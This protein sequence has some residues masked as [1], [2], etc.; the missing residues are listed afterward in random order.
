VSIAH[1]MKITGIPDGIHV[2]DSIYRQLKEFYSFREHRYR[3][4]HEKEGEEAI[5]QTWILRE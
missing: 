3:E 5:P 2:N 1:D 4:H